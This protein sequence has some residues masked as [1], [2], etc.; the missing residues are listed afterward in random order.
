M[1]TSNHI[2]LLTIN[3]MIAGIYA[4]L[5]LLL[6]PISYLGVQFRISEIIVLLAFYKKEYI[7]GL[8]IGCFLAN[9]PSPMG[10]MDMIFGTLSTIIVC[11]VMYY[12]HNKYLATCLGA[13]ITG[14]I[15]GGEL[16]FTLNTPFIAT[17]FYVFL[18]EYVVLLIGILIFHWLERNP[19]IKK[20]L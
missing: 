4:A 10:A 15:V 8:V 18:G 16:Y 9:I 17:A 2:K 20:Y 3:A 5:T 19:R 1:N 14:L 7:P 12:I 11:I 6:A 13:I